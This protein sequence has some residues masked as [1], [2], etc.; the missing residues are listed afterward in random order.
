M[1]TRRLA[2]KDARRVAD[3][4]LAEAEKIGQPMNVAV[5]DDGAHLVAFARQDGAKLGSIDIAIRKARTAVLMNMPT[6]ELAELAT[7]G[8]P[9]Y[10]IEVTNEGLAIFG[11]GV[12][13]RDAEGDLIGAVGV[14]AGTVEQDQ[15]VAEAGTN[16]FDP[17]RT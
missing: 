17:K 7:P 14:S 11:G 12:P 13:L 2:L 5:V 8:G 10:G 9:L 15:R 4:A 1:S 3:A 6:S 16:A